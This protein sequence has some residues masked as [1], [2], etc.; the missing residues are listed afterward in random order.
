MFLRRESF[1]ANVMEI[2]NT[3]KLLS[4]INT[5]QVILKEYSRDRL[6]KKSV[7]DD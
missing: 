2:I 4:E 7:A 3:I 6:I 1:F 5:I